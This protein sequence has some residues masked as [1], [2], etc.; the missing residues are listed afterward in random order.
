MH[1]VVFSHVQFLSGNED[2]E[3][4]FLVI[5]VVAEYFV[6]LVVVFYTQVAQYLVLTAAFS[7]VILLWLLVIV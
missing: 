3:S 4:V 1:F 7:P 5:A 2:N 6:V